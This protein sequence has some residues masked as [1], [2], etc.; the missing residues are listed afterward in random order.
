MLEGC[1]TFRDQEGE[2]SDGSEP[3]N[4]NSTNLTLPSGTPIFESGGTFYSTE[5][6]F[7]GQPSVTGS[8]GLTYYVYPGRSSI[9]G[10]L[11]LDSTEDDDDE[12]EEIDYEELLG[13][14][15]DSSLEMLEASTEAAKELAAFNLE[16]FPELAGAASAQA[17]ADAELFTRSLEGVAQRQVETL[18]A[19]RARVVASHQIVAP[20]AGRVVYRAGSPGLAPG[21]AAIMALSAGTGFVANIVMPEG[22]IE[23]LA[24]AG[25]VMFA[26]DHP[27][28]K[29][30]FPGE[31]R[32]VEPTSYEPGRMVATFDAQL[33][34]DAIG[35][36]GI[37]R[38]AVKVRLLWQPPLLD[39]GHFRTSLAVLLLGVLL[40]F[41]DHLR[42]LLRLPFGGFDQRKA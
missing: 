21:G 31:F 29:K 11:T 18:L 34:Q 25:R 16:M 23:S 12:P 10:A 39:S 3:L 2:D 1:N 5:Q 30:Y 36:L 26:L 24:G 35:L 15:L 7:T 37:G 4:L 17:V 20:F 9:E 28:L 27:V 19:E 40:M 33:P 13:I 42:G 41:S 8:D 14:S 22:E 6:G 32:A 38:E